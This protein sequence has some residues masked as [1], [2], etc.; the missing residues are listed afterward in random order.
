MLVPI[1]QNIFTAFSVSCSVYIHAHTCITQSEEQR[2]VNTHTHTHTHTSSDP[3][4]KKDAHIHQA[5]QKARTNQA[6]KERPAQTLTNTGGWEVAGYVF[7]I[8]ILVSESVQGGC[9]YI[10]RQRQEEHKQD[11]MGGSGRVALHEWTKHDDKRKEEHKQDNMGGSGGYWR[12]SK[13]RM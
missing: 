3:K 6:I 2:D 1:D 9:T 12:S 10:N 4:S 7:Q 8:G 11:K 13:R 5:I